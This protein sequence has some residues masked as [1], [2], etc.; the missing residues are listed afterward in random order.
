MQKPIVFISH[1]TMEKEI[2]ISLQE[3]IENAYGGLVDVFVASDR[4]SIE[5]GS[6][7]LDRIT[8]ALRKSCV[9]LIIT[10]PESVKRPWVNFEA[11]AGYI[12][13]IPVIPICHSGMTFGKL[14]APWNA[15]QSVEA[16]DVEGLQIV[17]NTLSEKLGSKKPPTVEFSPFIQA[18]K[19]YEATSKSYQEVVEGKSLPAISSLGGFA[20]VIMAY[21]FKLDGDA[22]DGVPIH[23]LNDF[24]VDSQFTT[25]EVKLALKILERHGLVTLMDQYNSYPD[26]IYITDDGW[27]WL[28]QNHQ[29]IRK[30]CQDEE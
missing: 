10:S 26:T 21:V 13:E 1:I 19:D 8:N 9:E 18:V 14:P 28:E 30:W 7:W 25:Y 5:L 3:L 11:G 22:R 6:L 23:E 20:D 29:E 16:T 4:K 15:L 24:A 2:A 27:L 17:L 12:R